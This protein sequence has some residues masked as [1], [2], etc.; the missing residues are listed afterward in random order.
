MNQTADASPSIF[1]PIWRR[2]WLILAVG[3]VAAVLSYAY[4]KRQSPTYQSSTQVFLGA[5]AEEQLPNA[6]SGATRVA[7]TFGGQATIVSSIVVEEV[8]HRLKAEHK[9]AA[10]KKA[11]IN[12]KIP[13]KSE[14][15]TINVETHGARNAALIANLVAQ[16]YIARQEGKRRRGIERAIAIAHRQLRRIEAADAAREAAA[17]ASGTGAKG[18][19]TSNVIQAANLSTKINEL[20]STLSQVSAVQIKPAKAAGALLLSPKPRK[21][22]IFAFVLGIVLAS[23]AVYAASRLDR[24]LR[25]LG[26]IEGLTRAPMLTVLPKVSRPIVSEA[27]GSRPSNVLL[28]PLRR[29]HTALRL[30]GN[31][32]PG[33]TNGD[34][35]R[36]ILFV[37]PDPGDGKSTV[38]ADLALVQR[39]AGAHVALVEANFRRPVQARL[40][41]LERDGLLG[42]V[43][44]GRLEADEA[45][46]RVLPLHSAPFP[47]ELDEA[48]VATATQTNVGSLFV[49]AGDRSVPNPPA[50]LAQD[51]TA[52]LL[53]SLAG[54]FDYVLVDAPS[55]LEVSDV[56]PLLGVVDGIVLVARVGHSREASAQRLMQMLD[57]PSYAPI[58]GVV[59]NFVGRAELKRYGFSSPDSR[60]W[61]GGTRSRR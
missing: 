31:G 7:K 57:H 19:S 22:A 23:I 46:Q 16:T 38:A 28:E 29:L 53:R 14:F 40:L 25:S 44:A 61:P 55:P 11:K 9:G 20:E 45:M 5:S 12:A 27:G 48:A 30:S 24:R 2:K 49:L 32:A 41:G 18:A 10:V 13:E 21:D 60:T 35:A 42:E 59:G 58:L 34:H 37:S 43:L 56:V 50:V 1:A 4:Y 26:A 3:V 54:R 15:M 39:D 51:N 8:R 36:V 33:E 52:E 47:D 6:K 17:A